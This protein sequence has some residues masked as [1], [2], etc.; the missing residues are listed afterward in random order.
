[1]ALMSEKLYYYKGAT[2]YS[3]DVY[4]DLADIGSPAHYLKIY[5]AS[6]DGYIPVSTTSDSDDSDLRTYIAGAVYYVK[7]TY[8]PPIDIVAG[9]RTETDLGALLDA[10]ISDGTTRGCESFTLD[11]TTDTNIKIRNI[12]VIGK[13]AITSNPNSMGLSYSYSF[14]GELSVNGGGS[15]ANVTA[16]IGFMP[17]SMNDANAASI[18]PSRTV[19]H[20]FTNSDIVFT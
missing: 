3:C 2:Q 19:P 11:S 14:T 1:M 7:K 6:G 17:Y 4:S 12:T 13:S 5:T 9:T 15:W 20:S 16:S 18:H 10:Y 8:T